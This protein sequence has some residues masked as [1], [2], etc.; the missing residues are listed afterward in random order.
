MGIGMGVG[1]NFIAPHINPHFAASM[2]RMDGIDGTM[3]SRLLEQQG[4]QLWSGMQ[5][6]NAFGGNTTS[7]AWGF[8]SAARAEDGQDHH[9][10]DNIGIPRRRVSE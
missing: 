1:G 9:E 3:D 2:G 7:P 10:S 5:H 4:T 8:A 6:Q